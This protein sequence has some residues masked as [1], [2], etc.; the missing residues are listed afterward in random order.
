[1]TDQALHQAD[2]TVVVTWREGLAAASH[3]RSHRAVFADTIAVA[4][5][6]MSGA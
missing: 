4:F 5:S 6:P 3:I 1:M 2:G